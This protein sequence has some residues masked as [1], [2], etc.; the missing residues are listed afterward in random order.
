M[1]MCLNET[2]SSVRVDKYLS[3][4]FYIENGLKQGDIAFQLCLSLCY[5]EGSVKTGQLETKCYTSAFTLR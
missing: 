2:Y 4:M 5:K 1:K 3:G